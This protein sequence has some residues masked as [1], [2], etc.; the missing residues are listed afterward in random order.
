MP[1][2]SR[3]K[4]LAKLQA[5]RQAERAEQTRRRRLRNG[6]IGAVVGL[7]VILVGLAILTSWGDDDPSAS[8]TPSGAS[9]SASPTPSIVPDGTPTKIGEVTAEATPPGQIA[10]DGQVPE[11]WTQP[12]PQFDEPPAPKDVLEPGT[13]YTAVVETSCGTFEFELLREVAP[14]AVASFVFLAEQGFF[15]GVWFHRI[16]PDFV[17][18]T[19]DPLGTGGG[20]PGYAFELEVDPDVPY[21][22]VGQVAMGRAQDPNSNGSQWFVTTGEASSL[23]PSDT[24]PGYTI[25]GDVTEGLDVVE[26]IGA[27]PTGGEAGDTPTLAVY[28]DSVTIQTS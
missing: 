4:Q 12:K 19:G 15:D 20:G 16:V 13:E 23:N 14:K 2:R 24:N 21:D 6:L 22:H 17:I 9:G 1:S 7:V 27:V 11:G 5:K 18:Q 8:P 10:C 28:V 26:E 25:F 3:E